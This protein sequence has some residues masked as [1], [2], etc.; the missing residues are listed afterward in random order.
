MARARYL[1]IIGVVSAAL[2]ALS[3]VAF[4]GA[5]AQDDPTLT[6]IEL[7]GKE[8]FFDDGLS[9]NGNQSCAFCHDPA[10]GFT[11]SHSG[12]NAVGGV[13]PGSVDT[14]FG[15]RK[16][17]SAAYAGD[18]P[19]LHYDEDEEVW[20]GG[21]FWDGRA[22]GEHLGDPLAE[23]AQGPYLNP[24][25]QALADVADLCEIAAAAEYAPMFEEVFGEPLDCATGVDTGYENIG[26]AV[27]AYERSAEVNPF[28]SKY[29]YYL[30]GE[31]ELT[32]QEAW[33]LDLF[34]DKAQCAECHISEPGPNGEPPLFTDFTYDNLG[35][36]RNPDNPFFAMDP[37]VNPDAD[38]WVDPGL[39]GY[40]K[41]AGF[42]EDVYMAEWGKVKVPTLRNVAK[43]PGVN[44]VKAYTHNG[45]FKSLEDLVH[46]YN[47]RDVSEWPV[48]EIAENVNT[49]EL[50]DLDLTPE[51]ESAVVAF[52][53]T[54]SDGYEP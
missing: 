5:E 36:P 16:P 45:Y 34:N 38:A 47:T 17:P 10:V 42:S 14:L 12:F 18:S 39:G 20:V 29:D 40:L 50:G 49:E 4:R 21:M 27:A 30:A 53:K 6:P 25:E 51:E 37:E 43:R 54:L 35:V 7:L 2:L 46:F 44:V 32:E 52:M 15:N 3:F 48:P 24:L 19:T 13:Y 33:G 9:L 22:T 11:G 23:Q 26:R 31:V 28:T 41:S 8:L 1:V